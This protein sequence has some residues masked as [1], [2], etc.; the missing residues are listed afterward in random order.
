MKKIDTSVYEGM[1]NYI[2]SMIATGQYRS[3][4]KLPSLRELEQKFNIPFSTVRRGIEALESKGLIESHHGSGNYVTENSRRNTTTSTGFRKIAVFLETDNFDASY[5]AQALNGVKEFAQVNN[6]ALILNFCTIGAITEAFVSTRTSGCDAALFLGCYDV[7]LKNMPITVPAVGLSMH[8][9]YEGMLSNIELD[10][11]SAADIAC[12]YFAARK[13]KRIKVISHDLPVHRWREKVFLDYWSSYGEAEVQQLHDY[14]Q[15]DCTD[16]DC[17][18]YFVSGTDCDIAAKSF[19]EVTGK[20]LIRER[21]VLS[22]DGKSLFVPGYDPVNT[23]YLDW[24][25]AGRLAMEEC[26]RRLDM[27]GA[28]AQR[29]YLNCQLKEV[30]EPEFLSENQKKSKN[31]EY[32]LS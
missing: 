1:V 18:Y 7:S 12:R 22:V 32:A 2:E 6:L 29:I 14:V 19:A 8:Q 11:F 23:I 9:S 27:P 25:T 30:E 26:M 20:K 24:K 21:I 5:C 16:S 15:A 3:G 10:P 13:C 28:G 31:R 4:A 17:G